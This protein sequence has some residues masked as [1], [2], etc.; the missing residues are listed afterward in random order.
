V[1]TVLEARQRQSTG[2]VATPS[3]RVSG[4]IARVEGWRLARH[5][6]TVTGGVLSSLLVV[7]F[8][9]SVVPVLQRDVVTLAVL[10]VPLAAGVFLTAQLAASRLQRDGTEPLATAAAASGSAR[11]AGLLLALLWPA[12]AATAWTVGALA[13]LTLSGGIGLPTG[14]DVLA[15]AGTVLLLGALGVGLGRWIPS[16]MAGAFGLPAVVLGLYI[17]FAAAGGTP[18]ERLLPWAD[19][20]GLRPHL[21]IEL[22]PRSPWVHL[23]YVLL[24]AATLAGLAVLRDRPAG[25]VAAATV[26]CLIGAAVTGAQLLSVWTDPGQLE[27]LVQQLEDP[28]RTLTCETHNTVEVCV[29]PR[30]EPW[31]PRLRAPVHAALDQVPTDQRPDDLQIVLHDRFGPRELASRLPDDVAATLPAGVR[32]GLSAPGQAQD[33]PRPGGLFAPFLQR[34]SEERAAQELDLALGAMAQATGFAHSLEMRLRAVLAGDGSTTRYG[35][36]GE[37]DLGVPA[38]CAPNLE[39]REVLTFALAAASSSQARRALAAELEHRP[40]GWTTASGSPMFD[41]WFSLSVGEVTTAGSIELYGSRGVWSRGAATL[42]LALA[43]AATAAELHTR[44]EHWTDPETAATELITDFG[45]APLRSPAELAAERRLGDL[46]FHP[47]C[48][49]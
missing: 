48:T 44:W 30:Y 24:C 21:F 14:G 26:A 32:A 38:G 25:D 12:A 16:G 27:A 43:D 9:W 29:P 23:G 47:D 49:E 41:D 15:P 10:A 2:P 40:Y 19:W 31:A 34:R 28:A 4:A 36:P 11:T 6:A 45:V 3:W 13:V 20:G 8:A 37:D 5:P 1:N 7:G 46:P 42:G 17:S 35:D 33:P 22:W 18:A 39:A